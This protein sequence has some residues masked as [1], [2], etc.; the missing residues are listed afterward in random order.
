M[1]GWLNNDRWVIFHSYSADATAYSNAHFGQDT[2]IIIALD[3]VACTTAES[4]LI[5]CAYD[6]NTGDCS[7]TD[8]AGVQC[9]LREFYSFE[10]KYLCIA[11]SES[12]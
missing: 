7:H 8:D 12:V 1:L 9:A 4:R 10:V 2:S 3:D 11:I 5:D 6:T